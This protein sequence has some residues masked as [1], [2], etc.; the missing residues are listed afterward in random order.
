M[1]EPM[2]N[3][4]HVRAVQPDD[5]AAR[6]PLWDG[7]NAFYARQ[8]ETAMA[9]AVTQTTWQRFFDPREPM[10]ALV[11]VDGGRV[12]GLAH[13]L[14]HRTM[15]KVEPVCYL[16]DLFTAASMRGLG[17]GRSLIDAVRQEA[18]AA[19]AARLYWHTQEGNVAGRRLYDQVA[20]HK[21]FIVYTVDL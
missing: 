5:Y 1:R 19:G 10:F 20:E 12:V 21:G 9:D 8:G 7:Y 6:R 3:P 14:F 2:T 15:T 16:S 17:V 4:L 18:R 11:A 13:Y